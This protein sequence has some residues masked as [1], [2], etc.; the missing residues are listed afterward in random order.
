MRALA[1]PHQMSIAPSTWIRMAGVLQPRED[2]VWRQVVQVPAGTTGPVVETRPYYFGDGPLELFVRLHATAG[3]TLDI[4]VL[5]AFDA[6]TNQLLDQR[7]LVL[8]RGQTGWQDAQVRLN[9]RG[10][11]GNLTRLRIA[12]AQPPDVA[13]ASIDVPVD[14]GLEVVDLTDALNTFDTHASI[15]DAHPNARAHRAIAE[16]VLGALRHAVGER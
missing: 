4:G 15:F 6:V 7:P 5:E 13:I 1:A 12:L 3:A 10:T 8:A 11:N 14:Y 2:A 9:L 16:Q